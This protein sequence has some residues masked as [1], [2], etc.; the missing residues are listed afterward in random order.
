MSRWRIALVLT[1]AV[2]LIAGHG[3]DIITQIEHWP[4]SYYPMYGR[5]QKKRLL[6]V[7]ALYGV[8]DYGKRTKG[9]RITSSRFVPQLSE[10]R[11]RNILIAAWGRDGSARNAKRNTAAILHDYIKL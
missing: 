4:F 8:F 2:I 11:I 6:R 10:A 5:V 1:L 3:Y 9:E 7:P